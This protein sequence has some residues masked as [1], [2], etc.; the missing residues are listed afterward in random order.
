MKCNNNVAHFNFPSVKKVWSQTK[1]A[2]VCCLSN[3]TLKLRHYEL[4]PSKWN[5]IV[6][7]SAMQINFSKQFSVNEH[8]FEET[9]KSY[10]MHLKWQIKRRISLMQVV[11]K[12]QTDTKF[13]TEHSNVTY[14]LASSLCFKQAVC[15][16]ET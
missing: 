6:C 11:W 1:N 13:Q 5:E 16:N 4:I 2:F 15:W 8:L 10:E 3:C 7:V 12:F 14:C 9:S